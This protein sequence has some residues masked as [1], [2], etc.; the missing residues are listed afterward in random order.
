MLVASNLPLSLGNVNSLLAGMTVG[1]PLGIVEV[2]TLPR[3]RL[4]N[5]A[6]DANYAPSSSG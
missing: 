5:T 2:F 3:E 4:W 6:I 1:R